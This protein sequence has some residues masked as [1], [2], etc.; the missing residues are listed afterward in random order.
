MNN[1]QPYPFTLNSGHI[2]DGF[3]AYHHQHPSP[4]YFFPAV[5]PD[6]GNQGEH[7]AHVMAWNP[8]PQLES[9][10]P[11]NPL[12]T[13]EQQS[14][15]Q[16]E[17]KPCIVDCKRIKE[18]AEEVNGASKENTLPGPLYYNHAWPANFWPGN[19]S[20]SSQPQIVSA[21]RPNIHLSAENHSPN[22]PEEPTT[23]NMESS[24]CNSAP[25][26]AMDITGE[27]P[28][29]LDVTN[30]D[31]R[32]EPLFSD[33]EDSSSSTKK[34]MPTEIEMQQFAREIKKKRVSAGFTQADVGYALGVL[35]GKMFSQTTIC[36]FE[37]LQLSYKNMCRLKPLLD[38]WLAEATNNDNLQ[39]MIN[40]DPMLVQSRKRKRRTNI[41]NIA[42]DS[43]EHY[44]L[45]NPKPG[46]QE[47]RQI[48]Q[49]LQ[50]EKDVGGSCLVL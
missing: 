19:P 14:P 16:N 36:R 37:S 7:Q 13:R 1:Q 3:G 33:G 42:K 10:G 40:R 23:S 38:S 31:L 50:L 21:P 49:N 35:Y 48:A 32:E 24:R 41:E 15:E 26:E 9:I 8:T 4:A 25:S 39:A 22:T 44:Y 29:C 45:A 30:E 6:N 2:P 11:F 18:E 28:S 20:V 34:K 47:M 12:I 17:E 27:A 43:L 46:T 5:R